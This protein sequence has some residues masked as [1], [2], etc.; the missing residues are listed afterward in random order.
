MQLK[1]II[2]IIESHYPRHLAYDWDNPGLLLGDEQRNIERVLVALDITESVLDEAIKKGA[3]CIISHHPCIFSGVKKITTED[4]IGRILLKAAENKIALYSA[5]T[6][7]DTAEC[8]INEK[9]KEMFGLENSE[10]IEAN[11]SDPSAGLGRIGD[12]KPIT[13]KEF[14]VKVKSV[15]RTPNLRYSGDED[16]I[17]KRVAIGSGSCSELISEA[18]RKGAD[19]IITGD[20]KYHICLE[21]TSNEFCIIDAGHFATEIIVT[22]M[23]SDILKDIGIE[24]IK[25]DQEDIFKFI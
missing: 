21:H 9:L 8:G 11:E 22:D 24:V 25:A 1:E 23:F 6:N 10:V 13:L 16:Q 14:L 20:L 17:I 5:H 7:M 4:F 19:T 18:K 12:I 15:L 3:D 2:K